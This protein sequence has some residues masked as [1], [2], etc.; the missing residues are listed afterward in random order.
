M[1]VQNGR[2]VCS[3]SSGVLAMV[4]AYFCLP[5][6]IGGFLSPGQTP[7]LYYCAPLSLAGWVCWQSQLCRQDGEAFKLLPALGLTKP[8]CAWY[9]NIILAFAGIVVCG[10]VTFFWQQCLAGWGVEHCNPALPGQELIRQWRWKEPW[11]YG[12]LLALTVFAPVTEEIFFR[13]ILFEFFQRYINRRFAGGM[14]VLVFG[15][16]HI[17][18]PILPGL[19]ILGGVL[20]YLYCRNFSLLPG[21]FLHMLNNVTAVALLAFAPD[22]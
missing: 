18:L 21:V 4:F 14:A 15:L 3:T 17:S 19:L 16:M 9:Y 6:L 20:Q 8:L 22:V 7:L 12:V 13:K 10:V 2:I 11:F 5:L 1:M